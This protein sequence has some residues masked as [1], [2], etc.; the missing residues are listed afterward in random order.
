MFSV[1]GG[2]GESIIRFEITRKRPSDG[3]KKRQSK[4][5]NIIRTNRVVFVLSRDRI[6]YTVL[7]STNCERLSID[8]DELNFGKIF[9]IIRVTHEY[10]TW[11][12]CVCVC[13]NTA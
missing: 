8:K 3:E 10:Y 4:C 9:Y 11:H 12:V 5:H 13:I 6:V 2:G 7:K 1:G